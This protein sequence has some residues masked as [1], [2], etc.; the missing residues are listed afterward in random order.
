MLVKFIS[1]NGVALFVNTTHIPTEMDSIIASKMATISGVLPIIFITFNQDAKFAFDQD[2][3]LFMSWT[4]DR[5]YHS[6]GFTEYAVI[7]LVNKDTEQA[8]TSPLYCQKCKS[9]SGKRKTI[10]GNLNQQSPIFYQCDS[11][12]LSWEIIPKSIRSQKVEQ[13]K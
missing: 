12:N 7:M 6:L 10:T 3:R 11:C 5:G 13:A 9:N 2:G 4:Q 1:G 8:L